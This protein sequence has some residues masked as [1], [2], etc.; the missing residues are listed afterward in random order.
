MRLKIIPFAPS[1]RQLGYFPR[2]SAFAVTSDMKKI[3]NKKKSA[4]CSRISSSPRHKT[5]STGI[6]PQ[7]ERSAHTRKAV[8][9]PNRLHNPINE[10]NHLFV[11]LGWLAFFLLNSI[12]NI[13]GANRATDQLT[14][15]LSSLTLLLT[16]QNA[17]SAPRRSQ[18]S[19]TLIFFRARS[20]TF[21]LPPGSFSL[22]RRG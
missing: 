22:A 7:K 6:R 5:T 4:A 18:E 20:N 13:C 3:K 15:S 1:P 8:N 11:L 14:G 9:N 16:M 2:V 21:C 10:A 12:P 19:P 17:P